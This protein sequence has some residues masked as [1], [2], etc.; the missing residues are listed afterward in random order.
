MNGVYNRKLFAKKA[1]EAR[2]KVREMGGVY[3]GVVS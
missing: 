2:D 3:Y 1:T